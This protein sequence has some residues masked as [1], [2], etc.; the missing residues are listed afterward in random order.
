MHEARNQL[1]ANSKYDIA[2]KMQLKFKYYGSY[3]EQTT[4]VTSKPV[5]PHGINGVFLSGGSI[6]GKNCVIFQQVTIG[7][8][9][10]IGSKSYG[11][12]TIGDNC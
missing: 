6:I 2:L 4:R 5:F 9:R 12:P 7:N 3:T 11:A 10:I 1:L 8:N